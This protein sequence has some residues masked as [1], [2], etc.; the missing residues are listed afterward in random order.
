[1]NIEF[2]PI[3]HF[4]LLIEGPPYQ[5]FNELCSILIAFSFIAI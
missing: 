1:L 5:T 2:Y 3:F 4:K